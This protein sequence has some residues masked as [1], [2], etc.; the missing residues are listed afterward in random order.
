MGKVILEYIHPLSNILFHIN[1][2]SCLICQYIHAA[3]YQEITTCIA[4]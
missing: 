4:G 1:V 3:N 2:L